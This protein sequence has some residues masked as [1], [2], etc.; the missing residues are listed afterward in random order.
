MTNAFYAIG[1]NVLIAAL[2]ATA[3]WLLCR[4]QMLRQQPALCHGLWLLVLLK[5]VVPPLA[6]IPVPSAFAPYERMEIGA[7]L[8]SAE[9]IDAETAIASRYDH[10]ENAIEIPTSPIDASRDSG[11]PPWSQVVVGLLAFSL[12][13]TLFLWASALHRLRQVSRLL[14]RGA[15][16][17]GREFELLREVSLNFKRCSG[18]S[19]QLVDTTV[20]PMLWAKPGNPTIILPRQLA[21]ALDDHQLRSILAHELGH[22]VRGDHWSNTFAFVVTSL[23]WWNPV[24][25]FARRELT[26][27]AE[28]CCDA[29]A[30]EHLAGS[31][32]VYAETLLAVIDF[33]TS[34]TVLR[35]TLCVTFGESH[36]LRRRF[37]MLANSSIT[38]KV[39]RA[40]WMLLALGCA[41][42]MLLPAPAQQGA[43][44]TALAATITPTDEPASDGPNVHRQIPIAGQQPVELAEAR[45]APLHFRGLTSIDPTRLSLVYARFGGQVRAIGKIKIGGADANVPPTER[46]LQVGD[47]VTRGQ[48]LAV[49]W[50]KELGEKM[51]E[52][53]D[54]LSRLAISQKKVLRVR[55]LNE[56]GATSEKALREA[57]A[58]YELA[59]TSARR[60]QRILW[61]LTD[62]E[63]SAI[64]RAEEAR[65]K[66]KVDERD[67][68]EHWSE[69]EIRAPF[70]GTIVER[71]AAVGDVVSIGDDLFKVADLSMLQ[72]LVQVFEEDIEALNSLPADRRRLLVRPASSP[73][74]EPIEGSFDRI[75]DVIDANN[76]SVVLVG[77]VNNQTGKLRA[78]QVVN[79]TID[80]GTET[81]QPK[82]K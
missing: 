1:W 74:T 51:A 65:P 40:G 8:D 27:A 35:P 30:V 23:F 5:L 68:V 52:L 12:C 32:K 21:D 75:G 43:A 34:V 45:K 6:S 3:V 73:T 19:L 26:A 81:T 64:R 4:T 80:P 46:K 31:R 49:V 54:S 69:Y 14:I 56:K 18:T 70:D 76:H 29:L 25:W 60:A 17:S 38:S 44:R 71:N 10:G 55:E 2:S 79:V 67:N 39:S 77:S 36:S 41:G 48:V 63:I 61:Q 22:F 66:E 11:G 57:Q 42:S 7:L 24:S 59:Q 58:E 15:A 37:E 28:A 47:R 33:V 16:Q 72:V 13:G 9:T 82:A 20:T 62:A 78:G 50:S 53:A